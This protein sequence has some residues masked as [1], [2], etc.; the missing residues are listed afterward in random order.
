MPTTAVP[1]TSPPPSLNPT[2]PIVSTEGEVYIVLT[3]E[4]TLNRNMTS[5][6]EKVLKERL[7]D[8]MSNQL[9]VED[10]GVSV[11]KIKI[12]YQQQVGDRRFRRLQDFQLV[13]T[14]ITLVLEVAHF[15]SSNK[16]AGETIVVFLE[17]TNVAIINLFRGDKE[18][19]FFY[20]TNGLYARVIDR[21]TIAPT[22][23]PIS[24]ATRQQRSETQKAS[25]GR[26]GGGLFY[27]MYSVC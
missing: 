27:L 18:H 24:D 16:E 1:T 19:P 9:A 26:S 10:Y 17:K 8:F 12:W 2:T 6:E 15:Q 11:E 5:A 25:G 13:S 23:A 21:V 4:N 22:P 14:A 7:L 20:Q 3:F